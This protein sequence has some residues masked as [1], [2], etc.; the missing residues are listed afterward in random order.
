MPERQKVQGHFVDADAA[1]LHF[2]CLSVQTT[3]TVG[4]KSVQRG[5]VELDDLCDLWRH[6]DGCDPRR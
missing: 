1:K 4:V 2:I 6:R 3:Q 5:C